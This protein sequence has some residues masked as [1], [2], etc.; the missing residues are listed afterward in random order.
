MSNLL[1]IK[2]RLK[3]I[4]STFNREDYLCYNEELILKGEGILKLTRDRRTDIEK[5]IDEQI[6]N[7]VGTVDNLKDLNEVVELYERRQK[8]GKKPVVSPDTIAVIAG[9]LLGIGLILSY[10]KLNVISTKA[11]GFVLRGRV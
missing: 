2:K 9:N 6:I 10:E 7:N 1:P 8:A 11:L 4:L 3:V 5:L